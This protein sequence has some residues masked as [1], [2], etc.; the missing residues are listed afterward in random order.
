[1]TERQRI[2]T[3][4]LVLVLLV[5]LAVL[6][7]FTVGMVSTELLPKKQNGMAVPGD[8]LPQGIYYIQYPYAG[9]VAPT[10]FGE[11]TILVIVASRKHPPFLFI[12]L[13]ARRTE[14]Q[15][16]TDPKKLPSLEIRTEN[17]EKKF[18]VRWQ[19]RPHA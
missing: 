7:S 15:E 14:W 12:S 1:M 19:P 9:H 8:T 10:T 13:N 3:A 11:N 18:I 16:H 17:G 6:L 4:P 5:T 2:E